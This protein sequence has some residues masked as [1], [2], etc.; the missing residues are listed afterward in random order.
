MH[1]LL[2]ILIC[3]NFLLQSCSL[4]TSNKIYNDNVSD[5]K[6]TTSKKTGIK[7]SQ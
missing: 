3:I 6:I 1:K 2:L 7:I 5:F 4:K